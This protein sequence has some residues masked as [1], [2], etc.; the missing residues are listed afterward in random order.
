[1]KF[2]GQTQTCFGDIKHVTFPCHFYFSLG[3]C[4]SK[5]VLMLFKSHDDRRFFI[6]AKLPCRDRD[7]RVCSW[8]S[9]HRS[10]PHK[11]HLRQLITVLEFAWTGRCV[12]NVIGTRLFRMVDLQEQDWAPLS[13]IPICAWRSHFEA[14]GI[15]RELDLTLL[16]WPFWKVFS[17]R[18]W[19]LWVGFAFIQMWA[20]IRSSSDVEW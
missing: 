2:Y 7:A 12:Q 11:T 3:C 15:N 8:R 17:S 1:M 5:S 13:D 6:Y 10:N 20:S 14:F 16:Q 9:I 19:N 18:S 4:F